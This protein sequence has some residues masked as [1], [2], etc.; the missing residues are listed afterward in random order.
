MLNLN[1]VIKTKTKSKPKP[2]CRFK[3]GS[4]VFISLYTTVIYN[5]AQNSSDYFSTWHPVD[6]INCYNLVD[7]VGTDAVTV[8]EK[9]QWMRDWYIECRIAMIVLWSVHCE[10]SPFI[11]SHVRDS[12]VPRFMCGFWRYI[13]YF[14]VCLLNFLPAFL[15]SL[16]SSV[17][18]LSYLLP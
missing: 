7:V 9:V 17:L 10:Q 14:F 15:P 16:L 1:K 8:I 12:N 2:A 3:N 18:M 13:N 4:R 5:T 6:V 11:S